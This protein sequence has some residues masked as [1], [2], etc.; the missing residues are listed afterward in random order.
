MVPMKMDS[1]ASLNIRQMPLIR[2]TLP[3]RKLKSS[4][5]MKTSRLRSKLLSQMLRT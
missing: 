5:M 4:Q 3:S 1:K 2:L